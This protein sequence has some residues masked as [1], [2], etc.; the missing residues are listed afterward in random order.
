MTLALVF[1]LAVTV[2]IFAKLVIDELRDVKSSPFDW[3]TAV[4]RWRSERIERRRRRPPFRYGTPMHIKG[5][6]T[7]RLNVSSIARIGES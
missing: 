4:V 2:A 1:V 5:E 7:I 6:P 3:V